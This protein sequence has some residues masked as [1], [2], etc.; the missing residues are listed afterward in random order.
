VTFDEAVDNASIDSASF[1]LIL[2]GR[3][4]EGTISPGGDNALFVPAAPLSLLARYECRITTG[5]RDL[6]GNAMANEYAWS[7]TTRD[8]SWSGAE[9][10]DNGT[11]PSVIPPDGAFPRVALDNGGNAIA[12]WPQSGGIFKEIRANRYEPGTG[13]GTGRVIS[14]NLSGDAQLPQVAVDPDGNATVVWMQAEGAVQ[15]IWA[16]RYEVGSGWGAPQR[17]DSSDARAWNP[18]V[19]TDSAGRA[20]VVWVQ[21]GGGVGNAVWSSRYEPGTGW[22]AAQVLQ[23]AG[24]SNAAFVAMDRAGNAVAVW[25]QSDGIRY[26]VWARACGAGGEWGV[27]QPVE[28]GDGSTGTPQ[29]AMD[30]AGN[31]VVAWSQVDGGRNH[32]LANRFGFGTGWGTARQVDPGVGP[33]GS[34]PQVAVGS[35]GNAVIGWY[36]NEGGVWTAWA[37]TNPDGTG[38]GTPVR[39]GPATINSSIPRVAMDSYGN[40]V[41]AWMQWSGT[42]FDLWSSRFGKD[43]GWGSPQLLETGSGNIASIPGVAMHPEGKAV[44]VWGQGDGDYG[45]VWANRFE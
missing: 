11:Q 41:A 33:D 21:G 35:N 5:I 45:K 24:N 30:E 10:V 28:S 34:S 7:F 19:A 17:V 25:D 37:S 13:W 4:V 36:A 31:A 42:G 27:P 12:V 16:C 1:R 23:D 39:I 32:I 38:W 40:A 3:E 15:G 14:S 2:A 22:G 26:N 9:S 6:A 44:V 43:S 20:L 29:L 8:G 18:Q